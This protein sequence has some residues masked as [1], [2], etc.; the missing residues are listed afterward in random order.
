MAHRI[1]KSPALSKVTGVETPGACAPMLNSPPESVD[2]TLW[3][4]VSSF[5]NTT[6]SPFLIVIAL[7][8][9][10]LPFCPIV[11]SAA[12]ATTDPPTKA[13]ISAGING[14]MGVSLSH[15]VVKARTRSSRQDGNCGRLNVAGHRFHERNE[16]VLFLF[17]QT[18][19][20]DLLRPA[21][22]T[23]PAVAV[24]IHNRFQ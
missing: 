20:L 4:T 17:R 5:M 12:N 22:T 11:R 19:H 8:E 21:W 3:V 2:I 9:N 1:V 23:D 18:E 15:R 10:T 6:T 16:V 24:V 13:I 7:S 14:L